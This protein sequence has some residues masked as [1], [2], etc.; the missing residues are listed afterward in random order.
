VCGDFSVS[1]RIGPP[2]S[3]LLENKILIIYYLANSGS[4]V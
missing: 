1:S 3:Y 4:V 2:A